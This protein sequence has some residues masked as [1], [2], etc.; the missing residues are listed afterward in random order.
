LKTLVLAILA[1]FFTLDLAAQVIF[2]ND[3][4]IGRRERKIR[5]L[6]ITNIT[7]NLGRFPN[8]NQLFNGR[9]GRTL[10]IDVSA[11]RGKKTF[12]SY[13]DLAEKVYTPPVHTGPVIHKVPLFLLMPPPEGKI[14]FEAKP[15][16]HFGRLNL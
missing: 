6:G 8:W 7:I 14:I 4:V 16:V 13:T 5:N 12:Y 9:G 10:V 1:V 3:F 11:L 15:V 2:T